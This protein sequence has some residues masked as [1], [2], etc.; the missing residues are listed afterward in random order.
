[1]SDRTATSIR[2]VT[3]TTVKA[4]VTL[5]G[6]TK[7]AL[8]ATTKPTVNTPTTKPVQTLSGATKEQPTDTGKKSGF[9][10]DDRAK[11]IAAISVGV[12]ALAGVG[13]Y[14]YKRK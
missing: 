6:I 10:F 3:S 11:K 9:I 1:M 7:P 13:Y 5:E 8:A 14:L 2:S 12:V 4:P